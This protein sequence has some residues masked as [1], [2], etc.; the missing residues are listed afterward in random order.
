MIADSSLL[1]AFVGSPLNVATIT[2]GPGVALSGRDAV[3]TPEAF[4]TPVAI[5]VPTGR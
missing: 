1:M 4:V 3:A 2:W 5:G